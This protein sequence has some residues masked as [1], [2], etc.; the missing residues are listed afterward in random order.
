M[1]TI[2]A[3]NYSTNYEL[4]DF[5]SP[6]KASDTI[7]IQ[8][9]LGRNLRFWSHWVPLLGGRLRILRRDT[10]GHGGS[11]DPGPD[12]Q[13]SVDELLLDMKGFLDALGLDQVHYLGESIGGTLGIAFAL[14]WP[15]VS[16]A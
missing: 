10:R 6:W 1:P 9:G 5:T 2:S 15:D 14:R 11:A 4:D 16:K 13:W 3:N 12:H 7:W 8:H